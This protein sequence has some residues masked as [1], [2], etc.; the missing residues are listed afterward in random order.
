MT[1]TFALFGIAAGF[2]N[3]FRITA[4][5]ERAEKEIARLEATEDAKR[6]DEPDTTA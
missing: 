4:Q 1:I 3:L 6:D 2:V 5:A